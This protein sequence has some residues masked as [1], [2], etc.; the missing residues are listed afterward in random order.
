MGH[1]G[2]DLHKRMSQIAVL[3][4]NGELAQHRLENDRLRVQPFFEEVLAPAR[5]ATESSGNWWWQTVNP[6]AS[7]VTPSAAVRREAAMTLGPGVG[8]PSPGAVP[9]DI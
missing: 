6:N 4:A 1:V 7:A 9:H 3:S 8:S 2:V 5:V